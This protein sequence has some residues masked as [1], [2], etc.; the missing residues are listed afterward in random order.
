MSKLDQFES[1]FKR[2]AKERFVYESVGIQKVLVITDLPGSQAHLFGDRVKRYLTTL[3]PLE[4]EV[5]EGQSCDT[6]G[7]LL[8]AV[9]QYRPDLVVT[10][11]NL[12]SS[13]WR[14]PYTLG[15]HLDVLTQ[16][17]TT[18]VLVLPRP[19]REAAWEKGVRDTDCVMAI[20]DHLAG[21]HRLV[22]YAAAFTEI[23]GAL[24]L[25]HVENQETFERY[26]S[27][28]SKI[29]SIDT[30]LA[31][32]AVGGQLLK[33]P[34]DFISSCRTGLANAS[35]DLEVRRLV[36]MGNQLSAYKALLEE[37]AVDLLVMNTKDDEQLAMHGLA[38]PLA[39]ELRDLPLLM[40]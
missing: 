28:I 5:L 21:D 29:P 20:T 3:G 17:T 16:V 27:A 30:E 35:V 4:F 31:R 2:A 39:I 19:E 22:N 38:H 14:W 32:Q 26:I 34:R 37:H 24:L 10:Y 15:S 25:T 9:E 1:T 23:G 40:L 11:R 36:M 6:V 33:E 7:E 12:H 8:D 18:P 13:A